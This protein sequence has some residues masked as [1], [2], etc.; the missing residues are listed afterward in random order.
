[1]SKP[2]NKTSMV[3]FLCE[4]LVKM[5]KSELKPGERFFIGGGFCELSDAVKIVHG[6]SMSLPELQA[7]HEAADTRILLHAKHTSIICGR[8]INQSSDT[9]VTVLSVY[10]FSTLSGNELWFKTGTRDKLRYIPIHSVQGKLG[11]S[12]CDSLLGFHALTG[13]ETMT[14]LPSIGKNKA[15]KALRSST[16]LQEKLV[17]LGDD[18]PPTE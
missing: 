4:T 10:F 15:L 16:S 6:N 9:D 7:D 3:C 17:T 2:V 14:R 11:C 1:M 12:V 18:I 5:G 13:C 8:L